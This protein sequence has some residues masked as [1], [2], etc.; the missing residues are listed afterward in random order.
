M[1]RIRIEHDP[2][3]ADLVKVWREDNCLKPGTIRHYV[4]WIRDFEIYC[5]DQ[6]LDGNA[7]LTESGA[8]AF[9]AWY[10]QRH[11]TNYD[12]AVKRAERALRALAYARRVMHQ[13]I[14]E[15]APML[16]QPPLRS[17]LLDEFATHLREHRGKPEGTIKK[18]VDHITRFMKFLK[19][20]HRRLP[21]VKLTDIDTFLI[22]C[23]KQYARA[24]TA[25]F[26]CSLRSF[27]RFLQATGRIA[28][29]LASA[30]A[31]PVIRKAERPLRALPWEDVQRILHGIDRSTA[32]G[33]RDYAM[34]LMMSA[35]GLGAGE[36]IRLTLEDIDWRAAILHVVRPKTGVAFI[37]PLLPAVARALVAYLRN[38]RPNHASSRCLFL[39]MRATH[40][41]L[42]CSSAIRHLIIKHARLA[43]VSASYLGSHVLRHSHACRQ[44]EQGTRPKLIGD[45]LGHRDPSSISAYI[46]ISTERLR[47]ISL[48]VPSW[49]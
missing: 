32:G 13:A 28:T 17:P 4:E 29:D 18:K 45:I 8:A 27:L 23:S 46:R 40:Q 21:H 12:T 26:S 24:T 22:E 5:D 30:V 44:M 9:A 10:V 49:R 25:D 34:L 35:Y 1:N 48:P 16:D 19:N 11:R 31:C 14:P 41:P 2:R 7:Q 43:G 47:Q 39:S 3:F 38:G 33:Q 42:S 36:I 6:S 15:W 37:L 20:H